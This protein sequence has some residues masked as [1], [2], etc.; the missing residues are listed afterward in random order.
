MPFFGKGPAK[1]NKHRFCSAVLAA[2]GEGKRMGSD[3]ILMPLCGLPAILYSLIAMEESEYIDE[4]VVVT[5]SERIP[6]IAEL[7]KEHG[8]SKAKKLICGGA[9][10]TESVLAGLSEID[11]RASLA[12]VHDAARPLVTQEVIKGAVEGAS[13]YLAAAPAV[14]VRDTIKRARDGVV[15]ETPERSELFAVQTPQV[16]QAEL[17]KGALTKAL[18]SGAEYTDDCSAVEALG[19]EVYLTEGSEENLKLTTPLDISIAETI[20][21]LR[22]Q[23]L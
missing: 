7:C 12:A 2:A 4:I 1:G 23:S 10:R 8:I 21:D 13:K 14:G 5:R 17:I 9:T 15:A 6:E 22:G 19:V 11:P 3:K 16:F 20:L 18:Q